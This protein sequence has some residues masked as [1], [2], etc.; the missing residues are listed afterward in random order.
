MNLKALAASSIFMAHD[1]L[2]YAHF[3]AGSNRLRKPLI[4]C[5][6]PP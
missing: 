6:M 1:G 5:A 2:Q 3:C 4:L